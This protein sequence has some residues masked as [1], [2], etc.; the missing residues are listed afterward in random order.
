MT[1][2]SDAIAAH[3]ATKADLNA[4]YDRILATDPDR[5]ETD[6]FGALNAR[7]VETERNVPWYRR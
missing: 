2:K 3:K 1:S 5:N 7:V 6:A 4:E